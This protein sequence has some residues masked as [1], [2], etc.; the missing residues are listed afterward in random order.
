MTELLAGMPKDKRRAW[1][2]AK[3]GRAEGRAGKY[4]YAS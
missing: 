1:E 3:T 4:D 2:G